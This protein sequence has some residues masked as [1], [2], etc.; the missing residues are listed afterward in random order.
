MQPTLLFVNNYPNAID[1][2][3]QFFDQA[4]NWLSFFIITGFKSDSL[5]SMD[6]SVILEIP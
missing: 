2:F 3:K 1:S 5:S 6:I 4:I